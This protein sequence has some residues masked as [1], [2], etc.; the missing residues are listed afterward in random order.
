MARMESLS[1]PMPEELPSPMRAV[2]HQLA[3]GALTMKSQLVK[4]LSI[5]ARLRAS[6]MTATERL[7][8]MA[9]LQQGEAIA[10]LIRAAAS[11]LRRAKEEVSQVLR[12]AGQGFSRGGRSY[13]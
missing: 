11:Q 3:K 10:D 7:D 6:R 13:R 2:G 1:M 12:R 5:D 9:S 8:A 4:P